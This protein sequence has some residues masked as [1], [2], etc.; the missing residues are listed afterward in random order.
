M[1]K[2]AVA[3]IPQ[4]KI[5][6]VE[7][8]TNLIKTKRTILIAD[9]SGIPGSQYQTVKKKIRDVAI[10]KVPKKNLFF[11]AL[12]AAGKEVALGLKENINGA[13]AVLFSDLDSYELAGKLLKN[14]SPS[15]AK[16][17]QVAPKDI[18]IPAGPTE[19]V[20]GP[21]ISELGG[22]GIQIMIKAGKIEIKDPKVVAEEGKAISQG[23]ADMLGKLGIKPFTLGFTPL[24]AYDSQDELI[25]NEIKIDTEGT[26]ESLLEAYSR[27]LPFAVSIGYY[28]AETTPLMVQKAVAYEK[29]LIRVITGEPEEVAPV[30]EEAAPAEEEV[31]EEKKE[32]AVDFGGFF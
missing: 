17:G 29:K 12:E 13:V 2:Q 23:A 5:N 16:A 26:T 6:A 21:A 3:N 18:E 25:Y 4:R 22:L 27:A 1:T 15:K 30:V 31:K 24:S 9:V 7:E 32:E 19:L 10:V 14:K 20:P 8:L 11:R 28:G